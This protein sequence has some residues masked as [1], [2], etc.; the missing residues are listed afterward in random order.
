[1]NESEVG[2]QIGKWLISFNKILGDSLKTS[3]FWPQWD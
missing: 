2:D 1:M 3:S